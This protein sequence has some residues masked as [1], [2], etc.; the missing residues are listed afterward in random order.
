MNSLMAVSAM[1]GHSP[2]LTAALA[3][4]F[5]LLAVEAWR[6]RGRSRICA[7]PLGEAGARGRADES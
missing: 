3:S 2:Y 5:A 1:L 6:V 7:R 4:T